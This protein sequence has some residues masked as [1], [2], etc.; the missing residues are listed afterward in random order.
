MG[1]QPV[2][3]P[4]V[5]REPGAVGDDHRPFVGLVRVHLLHVERHLRCGGGADRERGAGP[6]SHDRAVQMAADHGDDIGVRLDDRAQCPDPARFRIL[7][8]PG[9]AGGDRRVV[10]NEQSRP[11]GLLRQPRFQ[12]AGAN[13]IEAAAVPTDLERVED[14]DPDREVL[15]RILHIAVRVGRIREDFPED[16]TIV[17]IAHGRADRER[18]VRGRLAKAVV[19]ETVVAIVGDV[20]GDQQQV[21]QRR[22]RGQHAQGLVQPL[23]VIFVRVARIEAQ[24]DVGDLGD[25]HR[26][27]LRAPGAGFATVDSHG[28]PRT[29]SRSP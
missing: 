13:R 1:D 23:A 21:R 29:R 12:P 28:R 25:E 16:R 7:G 15:H 22:H 11:P 19:R 14:E 10:E 2:A 8:H 17:V 27:G 3:V 18:Q 9:K 4:V 24:V 6:A 26:Q 20:A 5:K